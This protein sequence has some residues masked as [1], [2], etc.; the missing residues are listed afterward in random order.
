MRS[1]GHQK[2]VEIMN[3]ALPENDAAFE[4]R[5]DDPVEAIDANFE[6]IA[7]STRKGDNEGKIHM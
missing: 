2:L 7:C 4:I 5:L 6:Y 3:L 1:L